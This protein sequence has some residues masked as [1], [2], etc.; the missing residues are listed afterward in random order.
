MTGA[1]DGVERRSCGVEFRA[2]GRKLEGYAAVFGSPARISGYTE[3]IASGAFRSTL[4]ANPDILALVDH[5][6]GRLLART[7]SGTLRLAEDRRGLHFELDLPPTQLGND[8]LALAERR[9]LGGMSFGFRVQDEAWPATDRRELRAVNLIEISVV[10]AFPAYADT[11]V[12]ARSRLSKGMTAAQRRRYL[13]A[14]QTITM[15]IDRRLKFMEAIRE[16]I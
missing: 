2:A 3:S 10:Q 13:A 16:G 12:S 14:L 1:A 8:I 5:D 6:P 7:A 9:D 15:P 11:S 4:A